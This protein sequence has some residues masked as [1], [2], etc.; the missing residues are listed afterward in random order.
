MKLIRPKS[1]K[2]MVADELRMRI[3]DGRLQLG[4]G[5]SENGLAAELGISKTPVREALLQLKQEGLVEVQPQ[6]GT[7]VFRMAAEQ[8]VM[9]SELREILEVA[10]VEMAIR[11][12]AGALTER[13]AELYGAMEQ[14]YE[15]DDPVG[16]RKLDGEY[17][18]AIIELCGNPYIRSAYSQIGFCIQALRS[19]LSHEAQL[20]RLSIADHR[21]MLRLVKAREVSALQA[22][23]RAHIQQT[24]QSYLDV[25]GKPEFQQQEKVS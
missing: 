6:R 10:A 3:I 4:A 13:M 22:L 25:L 18:E 23:M 11:R 12:N 17:H 9:I 24:K 5:L 7:Y 8:V 15:A 20:N 14:A 2:E 21:E 19:R 1:L 16:Y